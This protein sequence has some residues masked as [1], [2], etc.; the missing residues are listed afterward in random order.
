MG[1]CGSKGEDEN[2][3]S[4]CAADLAPEK[5]DAQR[6]SEA[7]PIRDERYKELTPEEV[8]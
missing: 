1:A 8:A 3:V 7:S 5:L 2:L 6:Y 4:Q